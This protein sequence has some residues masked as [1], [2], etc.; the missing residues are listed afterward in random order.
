[1][2]FRPSL[3]TIAILHWTVRGNTSVWMVARMSTSL[4]RQSK[5]TIT[6]TIARTECRRCRQVGMLRA[7]MRIKQTT[8]AT[9]IFPQFWHLSWRAETI[10]QIP[11]TSVQ[12]TPPTLF[13][14]ENSSSNNRSKS[15]SSSATSLGTTCL[16]SV[17]VP[18][19]TRWHT[20]PTSAGS[21]HRQSPTTTGKRW[22][23]IITIVIQT[24][25][26]RSQAKGT[27]CSHQPQAGP[28]TSQGY[29]IVTSTIITG[30][31]RSA[32]TTAWKRTKA[33]RILDR[34]VK[35]WIRYNSTIWTKCSTFPPVT[36][37]WALLS[38]SLAEQLL[39]PST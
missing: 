7:M 33:A 5:V 9:R 24:C 32:D 25:T 35:P 14:A 18:A 26:R 3:T 2:T 15:S 21:N 39:V 13:R 1:M 12:S 36:S 17:R 38:P 10:T 19:P 28:N 20:S 30:N 6:T 29:L 8:K 23:I 16:T 22:C 27:H 11:V 31:D 37:V 34:M 4:Y